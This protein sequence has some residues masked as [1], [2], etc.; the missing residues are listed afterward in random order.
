MKINN[1]Y[2]FDI[3]FVENFYT[4]KNGTKT[5]YVITTDFNGDNIPRDIYFQESA[6][7]EFGNRYFG[8]YR[9][10]ID[11][12]LR[13]CNA[14]QVEDMKFTMILC[15]G[16]YY[17]SSYRHDFVSTKCGSIDGGSAYVKIVGQPETHEFKIVD[18]KFA[19]ITPARKN[20]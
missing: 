4:G 9:R 20:G 18:G 17:Y 14:D 8:L 16:E 2:N 15:D 13:I 1:R 3:S 19:R 12:S 11:N 5:Q 6:H 10:P 7:P